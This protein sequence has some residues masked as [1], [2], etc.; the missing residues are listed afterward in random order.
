M[1]WKLTLF[2]KALSLETVVRIWDRYLLSGEAFFMQCCVGLVSF[3]EPRLVR[4]DTGGIMKLLLHFPEDLS[5]DELFSH[6]RKRMRVSYDD[7]EE[8]MTE[9]DLL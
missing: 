8:M 7:I 1:D 4:M 5:V 3:Y 2:G 6:M 9:F